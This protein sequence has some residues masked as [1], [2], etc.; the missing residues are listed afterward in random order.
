M[1]SPSTEAGTGV[2]H[3]TFLGLSRSNAISK[4]TTE[5]SVGTGLR[6]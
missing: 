4:P 3:F 6:G 2:E 1:T 5:A